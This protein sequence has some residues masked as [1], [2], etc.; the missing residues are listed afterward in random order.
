MDDRYQYQC[1]LVKLYRWCRW[2]P[3]Y[4]LKAVV[5]IVRYPNIP[6]DEDWFR[7]RKKWRR[8]L[9]DLHMAVAS[10]KMRHLYTFEEVLDDLRGTTS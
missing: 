6:P 5:A 4:A 2:K 10:A 8:H 3:W 7:T 9:W 1:R